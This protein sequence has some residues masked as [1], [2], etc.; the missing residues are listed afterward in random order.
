MI[1]SEI[2]SQQAKIIFDKHLVNSLRST[3]N[4]FTSWLIDYDNYLDN[5]MLYTK[6]KIQ[7]SK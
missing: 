5:E 2:T 7:K 6:E 1:D 4:K 3:N